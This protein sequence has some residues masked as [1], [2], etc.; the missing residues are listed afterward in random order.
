MTA[1]EL[2]LVPAPSRRWQ[3]T[4]LLRASAALHGSALATTLA[5]PHWW[6]W[7]VGALFANHVQLA[8][9]GL[10]PRSHALG[11][12]WTR[13]PEPA[14]RRGEVAITIDDGPDPEVTPAVLA[15][16][17]A[18][19]ARAT[20]FFIGA[21]AERYPELVRAC[22]AQ[23]HAVEN[24][25]HH[26]RHHF[27]VLGPRALRAEIGR[28]QAGL[29]RLAGRTPAFFRAPAGLRSPLL[30]PVLQEL[31]LQLTS[32]TRRGFDTVRQDAAQ[33]RL[34]LCRNL[35]AGDILLLHDG[36]A[37]RTPSGTPIVV[38][39]LPGLLDAIAGASL[40]PVTLAEAVTKPG[41]S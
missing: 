35:G 20:F 33:V 29:A 27:S 36:H 22:V 12:N 7:T 10:W 5:Q 1:P 2:P 32:W 24:H 21:R 6:P 14:A 3:P 17:A 8:A 34:R 31:G 9:T 30:E 16:L 25:S 28:A 41:A 23:G 26:H 39:V 19:R 38:A 37:A 13:L 18:R 4:P 15:I 40:R 11:P